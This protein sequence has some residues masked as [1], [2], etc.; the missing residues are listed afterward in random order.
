MPATELPP[1]DRVDPA[2]AWQAWRPDDRQPWDL[3]WAAHLYRRAAFGAA[4]ADLKKAVE[5]GLDRTLEQVLV[6]EP[7]KAARDEAL[8]RATGQAVFRG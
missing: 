1:L 5:Q 6:G 7:Q 2:G 3:K 4:P 8:R